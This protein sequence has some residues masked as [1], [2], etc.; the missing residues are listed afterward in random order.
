MRY[1]RENDHNDDDPE[2][3]QPGGPAQPADESR[4]PKAIGDILAAQFA[5]F[6]ADAVAKVPP[7]E[8]DP[9]DTTP[10]TPP[11]P[12]L[13]LVTTQPDHTAPADGDEPFT[14][15]AAVNAARTARRKVVRGAASGSTFVVAA[16]VFAGWGEPLIVAGPLAVYGAGWLAYLWWNAALRPSLGQVLT[17][18]FGA[19][20]TAVAVVLTTLAGIA[21]GLLERVDTA[22]ARHETTRTSPASPSA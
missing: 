4:E 21:R 5:S 20:R 15:E 11:R 14:V 8:P 16:G 17:T 2:D 18:V 19:L 22:R 7:P 3:Y 13:R 6:L 1:S 10:A 9:D 12:N